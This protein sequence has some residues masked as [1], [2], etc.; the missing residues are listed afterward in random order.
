MIDARVMMQSAGK[1]ATSL[2]GSANVL[3]KDAS[4]AMIDARVMM[5]SAGKAATSLSSSAGTLQKDTSKAMIDARVMMQKVGKTTEALQK[6]VSR[7]LWHINKAGVAVEKGVNSTLSEDSAL[8]Y[9]FQQLINDLSE[10]ASS[11]SVLA[12]TLQR[13]PNALILGK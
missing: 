11:F 9:R 5:Q 4:K 2:S 6:D 12:D 8:Q 7:T 1:A 13:K 3:Q 10:A